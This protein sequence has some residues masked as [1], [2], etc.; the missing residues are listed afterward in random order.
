MRTVD[1]RVDQLARAARPLLDHAFCRRPDGGVC[2]IDTPR[3]A[4]PAWRQSDV[5]QAPL[6]ICRA[7]YRRQPFSDPS[8]APTKNR[9]N[10]HRYSACRAKGHGP[11][12]K[13]QGRKA[14]A[15][16]G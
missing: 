16:Q 2:R 4:A 6:T 5:S 8:T 1:H 15:A 11:K 13:G 12:R 7:V 9:P 3:A 10:A 14:R